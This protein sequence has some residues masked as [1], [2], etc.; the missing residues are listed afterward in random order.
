MVDA[1]AAE[2]LERTVS[3]RVEGS[4][5]R[6]KRRKRQSPCYGIY[7]LFPFVVGIMFFIA[8]NPIRSQ[9]PS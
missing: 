1:Q 8:Q 7:M 4:S 9:S 5:K 6:R 2:R 3:S